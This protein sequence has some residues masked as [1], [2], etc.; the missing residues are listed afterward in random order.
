MQENRGLGKEEE[1]K[2]SPFYVE[3]Y[4]KMESLTLRLSLTKNSP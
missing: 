2:M 1:I 3:G 4:R